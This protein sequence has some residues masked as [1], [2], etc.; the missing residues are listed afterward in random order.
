[1]QTIETKL[2]DSFIRITTKTPPTRLNDR[3]QTG[4]TSTITVDAAA[5]ERELRDRING[6]VRFS[7]GDR[8]M[9]A[10]DAG[11]YRMVPIGVV[12]PKDADDVIHVVR[13]CRS[14][15]VPLV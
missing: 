14:H 2:S 15:K 12:L 11:N 10:S 3:L 4:T 9:Y 5:L 7:D 8:G 6:E 1:M 13:V